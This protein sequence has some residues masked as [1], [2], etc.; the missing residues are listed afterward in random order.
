MGDKRV[1]TGSNE[2]N[3]R[4]FTRAVLNDLHAMEKM[5][6][7]GALEADARRIGAE[8]EIFLIDSTMRPAPRAVEVMADANDPR[9]TTEIG[10]FNLEANLTPR[11]FTG[12]ALREMEHELDEVLGL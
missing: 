4:S 10:R 5:L 12:K 7:T 2:S 6:A 8:Q 1:F 9:L 11:N 3:L